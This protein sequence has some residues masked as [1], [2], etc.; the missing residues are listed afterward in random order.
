MRHWFRALY[1]LF[2][3]D[4]TI[5]A[6]MAGADRMNLRTRTRQAPGGSS[7]GGGTLDRG[8]SITF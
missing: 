3:E 6:V 1:D 2:E 7:T 4:G 5:R 8:Q